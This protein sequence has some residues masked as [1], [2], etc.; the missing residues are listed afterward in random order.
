[1][2]DIHVAENSLH[3]TMLSQFWRHNVLDFDRQIAS[4]LANTK[5]KKTVSNRPHPGKPNRYAIGTT[6]IATTGNHSFLCVALTHTDIETLQS[7][8][9]S[10]DLH[11]AL[12]GLLQKARQSCSGQVLNVPLIGSGLARTGIKPN[13]IVDLI[14]LAIFE[15]S[16]REKITNQIRIVL[17][18]PMRKRIDL[19]TLQKDWG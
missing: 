8:A 13:I 15:E 1:V 3:G 19:A 10:D 5:P 6:A 9:G 4:Q 14:L 17:P 2:D 11:A 12:R 18:K 7:S 16:K